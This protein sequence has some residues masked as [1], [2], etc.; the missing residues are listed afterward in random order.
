MIL[1]QNIIPK[2]I[3]KMKI[4]TTMKYYFTHVTMVI[5]KVSSDVEEDVEKREPLYTLGGNANCCSHY[6]KEYGLS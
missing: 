3:T 2:I 1:I 5:I 6:G 4:K